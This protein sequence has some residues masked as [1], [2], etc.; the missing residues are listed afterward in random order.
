MKTTNS[1]LIVLTLSIFVITLSSCSTAKKNPSWNH[2]EKAELV[3][4]DETSTNEIGECELT[5]KLERIDTETRVIKYTIIEED[6]IGN[7]KLLKEFTVTINEG[8]LSGSSVFQFKCT[9]ELYLKAYQR[10][11]EVSNDEE[12]R[13][14]HQV[15]ADQNNPFLANQKNPLMFQ[16]DSNTETIKCVKASD[17]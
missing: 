6:D 4:N 2:I 16:V 8:S 9:D 10:E 12:G 15:Y 17:M 14:T 1:S 3:C 7:D 11:G 5:T 13:P